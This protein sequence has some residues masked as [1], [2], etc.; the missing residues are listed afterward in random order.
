M[1]CMFGGKKPSSEEWLLEA[2]KSKD[3]SMIGMYLVH[4]GVVRS[5]AKK[6]I[7][8][9]TEPRKVVAMDFSCDQQKAE[10]FVE[11]IL[12]ENGVYYV[13]LW[14]A[15]GRLNVGD[16]IMQ[17]L[18]GADCRENCVNALQNL[19]KNIKTNCVKEK[20]LF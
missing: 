20:E 16:D 5:T 3:A 10:H 12:K 19:V 1:H 17:V 11:E 8:E 15:D 4:N 18:V 7:Y 9:K 6:E 13:K 14:L 2:K